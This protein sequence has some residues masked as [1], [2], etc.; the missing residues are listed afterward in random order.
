MLIFTQELVMLKE[1]ILHTPHLMQT[2]DTLET[3]LQM[4]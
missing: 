4:G 1:G 2:S 3:F